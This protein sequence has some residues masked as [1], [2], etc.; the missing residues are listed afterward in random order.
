MAFEGTLEDLAIVDVLQLLHVSQKTGVLLVFRDDS[1][2]HIVLKDGRLVGCKHPF[3][4]KNIG[5]VLVEMAAVTNTDVEQALRVQQEAG[6]S[7]RPLMATLV[8]IGKLDQK[9]G[10]QALESLIE[11]TVVELVSWQEGH[12]VFEAGTITSVDEFAHIPRDVDTQLSVDTQLALMEAVRILD[13]RNREKAQPAGKAAPSPS[14]DDENSDD[15][16]VTD[17][18]QPSEPTDTVRPPTERLEA[19][20][21][22]APGEE[23]AND[24][25][26]LSDIIDERFGGDWQQLDACRVILFSDDGLLKMSMH[27]VCIEHNID[28]FV[29]E[30]G[31][32]VFEKLLAWRND[33]L[34]PILVC[35]VGNKSSQDSWHRQCTRLLARC[36]K[37]HP[38]IP[39]ILLSEPRIE[40]FSESFSQGA[41]AVLPRPN[42][43]VS[44]SNYVDEMRKLYTAIVSC[45]KATFQR[46]SVL[47]YRLHEA[48]RRM[49]VLKARIREVRFPDGPSQISLVVL[50]HVA[51]FVE[52]C[53]LFLVRKDDLLALGAFGLDND[54]ETV[55]ST[56][57]RLRMPINDDSLVAKTVQSGC[58]YCGNNGDALLKTHLYTCIGEPANPEIVLVPL[59]TKDKTAAIIY[60]DFGRQETNLVE[61][62]SLE[63][64][65]DHAGMAF[66]LALAERR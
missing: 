55:S 59:R 19:H 5:Q 15:A 61:T 23:R 29:T 51:E 53:V 57:T 22:T 8:E 27:T 24:S 36:R 46:R 7:R 4:T 65:A 17:R 33:E 2:A 11:S 31:K 56:I 3:K 39:L 6:D 40:C 32:D 45:M 21:E 26:A 48:R 64:L 49:G 34:P 10:W 25:D 28:I 60:G 38:E 62:D 52:R 47:A 50:R 9:T 14:A 1:E 30:V 12:F 20:L 13:E 37:E 63:I 35:D 66:E 42:P 43:A 44:R 54:A 41:A 18:P 58:F 16:D